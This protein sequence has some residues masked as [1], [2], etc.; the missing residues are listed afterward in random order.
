[1]PKFDVRCNQCN[2]E[3]EAFKAY[4][5]VVECPECSSMDSKTLMPRMKHHKAKDPFDLVG[6]GQKV[7]DAKPIKSYANDRR[8]GGKDTT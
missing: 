8:K 5:A 3:W 1:M 2:H 6:M 7:P 4:D